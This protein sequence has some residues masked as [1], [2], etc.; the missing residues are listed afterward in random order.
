ML[1]DSSEPARLVA[2]QV[3]AKTLPPSSIPSSMPGPYATPLVPADSKALFGQFLKILR[4]Q[5]FKLVLFIAACMTLA[6]ILQYAS[7]RL[8]SATA[9]LRLDRHSA[10]GA[11]GQEASQIST[12]N[13]MDVIID[14]DMELAQSDPVIRPVAQE[15]HLLQDEKPSSFSAEWFGKRT[16][17]DATGAAKETPIELSGL[18]VTRPANTYLIRITY[19]AWK[20]PQLAAKVA[21]GIAESLVRHVH[22]SLDRSYDDLSGAMRRDMEQ[23]R[24]KMDE[25]AQKLT[26]YENELNMVDPEQ[27]STVLTSRLT[28]LLAEYTA[29][30]ADRMRK[31]AALEDIEKTPTV[32]AMEATEADHQRESLLDEALEHLSTVRQQFVAARS[33]Y[34]ENHPEYRKSKQQLDEAEAQVEKMRVATSDKTDAEYQQA[35]R[36]E[37]LLKRQFDETK[38]EVDSLKADA[39]AYSQLKTEAENDRRMYMD[40]E[41]HTRDADVNRQ[42]RDATVQFA[43]PALPPSDAIFPKLKV[44]LPIAFVFALLLGI[45]GVIAAD[46]L[47]TT[48]SDAED[49]SARL[50]LDIIGILPEMGQSK[51]HAD[52]QISALHCIQSRSYEG[53][54]RYREAVRMLRN[55]IGHAGTNEFIRTLLITSSTTAE[56]RSTTAAHLA[57]AC[58]QR[59]K[60]VLL[61]DADLRSPSLHTKFELTRRI[62]LADVLLHKISPLDVIVETDVAGLFVMPAGSFRKGTDLISLGFAGVLNKV[63]SNFDLLIIDGPPVLGLS[64]TQELATMVDGVVVIGK[65]DATPAKQ[66]A[67][68]L[69]TLSRS[70][71]NVLGVVVNQVRHSHLHSLANYFQQSRHD[72]QLDRA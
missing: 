5:S 46:A 66:L 58:A 39:L 44:N 28:Q 42:F 41:V 55:S 33:Y 29:A 53:G 69:T 48:F 23:L 31:Q 2:T 59:G 19:R 24:S 10:P 14:T 49:L 60:R 65:A 43:A 67:E 9:L 54:P 21:N 37:L 56:G 26:Q 72:E 20:D 1:D 68:T 30:Q 50:R 18:K 64:E 71:A 7:P 32:A 57:E 47:D 51:A 38:A 17:P 63:R 11:V 12:I 35:R 61:I 25:S 52:T 62:G 36:R 4:K 34:G 16:G 6:L 3:P 70:R 8:Y 27:R 15:F 40:L 13:D 45:L 22:E